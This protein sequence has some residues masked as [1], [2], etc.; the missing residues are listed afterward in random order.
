MAHTLGLSA[1]VGI[2]FFLFGQL[3]I[4]GILPPERWIILLFFA[5]LSF[6][7]HRIVSFAMADNREK[8]IEYFLASVVAR[9]LLSVLFVGCYLY[10]GVYSVRSFIITF[11]VLYLFYTFFEILGLYRNLQRDLKK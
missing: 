1:G 11:F 7:T 8:F 3:Q 6:F 10:V 5:S 4:F 2:A 9:L